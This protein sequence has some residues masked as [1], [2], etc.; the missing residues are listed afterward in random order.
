MRYSKKEKYKKV[1]R[2]KIQPV[3]KFILPE[4]NNNDNPVSGSLNTL[5]DS[6]SGLPSKTPILKGYQHGLML[7]LAGYVYYSLYKTNPKLWKT[8]LVYAASW[9]LTF[10]ASGYYHLLSEKLGN[11]DLAQRIDRGSIFALIAG[12]ATGVVGTQ[13]TG[14]KNKILAL[15]GIYGVSSIGAGSRFFK[16]NPKISYP[17]YLISGW[18]AGIYGISTYKTSRKAFVMLLVGG[19]AYSGGGV[20]FAL[21]K[22]SLVNKYYQ[23]HEFF[24]S[25]TLIGAFSHYKAV[26]Y[27]SKLSADQAGSLVK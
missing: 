14:T 3:V 8:H 27:L 15:A 13:R 21:K 19:V 25:L 23:H 18:Y 2:N 6:Q 7:P 9:G 16:V 22:P 5:M 4:A 26:K 17:L 11:R 1:V 10:G 20:L 24:H 12:S